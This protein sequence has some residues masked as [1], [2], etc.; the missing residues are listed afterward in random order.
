MAFPHPRP[1][2]RARE[3]GGR[4]AGVR[5][6][7][8]ASYPFIH[9]ALSWRGARRVRYALIPAKELALAKARLGLALDAK[10]RRRLSLALFQ[11]VLAAALACPALDRV[12]VVTR[13]GDAFRLATGAGA[14]ALAKAGSL[15][16]ALASAARSLAERGATRLIVLA[17]DLPLATPDEIASVAQAEADVALVPSQD[18]GTN[19]LALPPG[20][21]EFQFGP[22]SASR[23]LA[24]ARAAGLRVQRLDLPG[25]AFDI[26]TPEDL[27]ELRARLERGE[28]VGAHTRAALEQLAVAH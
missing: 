25:L 9:S 17:A 23:H 7:G 6:V 22:D 2:S 20:R 24:A 13:G 8:L 19:A 5:A 1:L 11:D 14:E 3:R 27:A 18:G 16:E 21:L 4:Q 15:N 12:A 28:R 10:G 26:D